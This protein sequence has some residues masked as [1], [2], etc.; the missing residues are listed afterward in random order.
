MAISDHDPVVD[1][2]ADNN[3]LEYSF[4]LNYYNHII[5]PAPF[6]HWQEIKERVRFNVPPELEAVK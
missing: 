4:E 6:I 5:D 2:D 1:S 3:D